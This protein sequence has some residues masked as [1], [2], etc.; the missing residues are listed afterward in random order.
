[1]IK[2]KIGEAAGHIWSLL[3]EE[4]PTRISRLQKKVDAPKPIFYQALGWLAR[5]GKIDYSQEKGRKFVA[6]TP[7]ETQARNAGLAEG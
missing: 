3:A 5:E 7:E 4:G 6:L 1:M 2:A